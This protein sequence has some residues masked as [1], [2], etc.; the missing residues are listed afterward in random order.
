MEFRYAF[1]LT[2]RDPTDFG[3]QVVALVCYRG[4]LSDPKWVDQDLCEF[5]PFFASH[6]RSDASISAS[7]S[8]ICIICVD[9]SD[10]VKDLHKRDA[11]DQVYYQL[12]YDVIALFGFM[13]I[14]AYL[15]WKTEV[16]CKPPIMPCS[17]LI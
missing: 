1:S 14:Q 11:L 7:F 10:A 12:D 15:S 4:G 16:S 13:E 3:M 9:L 2:G 5:L 6:S 17:L 8:T